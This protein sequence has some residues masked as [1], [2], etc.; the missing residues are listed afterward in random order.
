MLGR[1]AYSVTFV[2]VRTSK[3]SDNVSRINLSNFSFISEFKR[4]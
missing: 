4:N 3:F 2:H 1:I